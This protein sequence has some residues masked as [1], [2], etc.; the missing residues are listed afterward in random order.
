MMNIIRVNKL[1]AAA[2][3][4]IAMLLFMGLTASWLSPYDPFFTNLEQ[5]LLPPSFSHPFGTDYLGRDLLSRVIHGIGDSVFPVFVVLSIV[6][7][8]GLFVGTLSA[9]WG[10]KLDMLLMSVTDI[11]TALPS[12]LLTIV[13]VGFLGFGMENVYFAVILSWWAK[14][15]RLI[16]GLIHDVKKEPYIMASRVSGSFGMRTMIRHMIPNIAPQIGTILILDVSKVILTLSGLSFLGIGAQPPS[17]EWGVMLL[18]GKNY[19]QVAPWMGFFPGLM[20]FLTACSFQIVGE[21]LRKG[22]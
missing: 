22:K 6:M 5:K 7:L 12:V 17:P 20:I 19:L 21:R 13:V 1:S 3:L 15:V 2:L 16:R 11:F 8:I 4:F 10:N 9:F 18:D 14:Y